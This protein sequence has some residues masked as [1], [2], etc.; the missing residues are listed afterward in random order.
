M[1]KLILWK[2]REMTKLRRDMDRLFNRFC[3]DFGVP[4]FADEVPVA[5]SINLSETE[6]D[7]IVEAKLPGMKPEDM[8]ISATEDSLIIKG[9]TREETVEESPSYHRVER[10]SGSFS[11]TISLPCKVRTDDIKASYKEG[12][13]KIT[14]PKCAPDEV[15]GVRIEVK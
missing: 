2:D 4:F 8:D 3:Y 10:R 9:E 1:S 5:P 12:I 14:M 15:R 7:L 6:D 13:L 11:R